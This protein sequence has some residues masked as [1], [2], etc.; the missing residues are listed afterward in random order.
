MFA[1]ILTKPYSPKYNIERN[2]HQIAF[3]EK[4]QHFYYI[5]N[6]PTFLVH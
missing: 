6:V 2:M 1:N 4:V 5:S 3:R